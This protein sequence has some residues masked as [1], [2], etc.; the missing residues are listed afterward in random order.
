MYIFGQRKRKRKCVIK[1]NR[2]IDA[3]HGLVYLV[4][5]AILPHCSYTL[6]SPS[7]PL[8]LKAAPKYKS[9]N[10]VPAISGK[11]KTNQS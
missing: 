3:Q 5:H 11:A 8:L 9:I 6:H 7:L 10:L 2:M 4:L 1:N